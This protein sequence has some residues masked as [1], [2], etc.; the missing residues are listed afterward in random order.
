[1]NENYIEE[2]ENEG[3]ALNQSLALNKVI[4][5][6]LKQQRE[7]NKRMFIALI[8][9][10]LVNLAIVGG[11]LWYESQWEYTETKEITQEVSGNDSD[12]NNVSGNQYKDSAIHN[13]GKEG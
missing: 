11:F 12:I 1:M 2:M 13:E 6:L 9:S 5:N 3:E 4:I 8:V 7:T 10:I